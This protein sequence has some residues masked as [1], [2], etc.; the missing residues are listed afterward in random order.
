MLLDTCVDGMSMVDEYA[1]R[2]RAE[3]EVILETNLELICILPCLGIIHIVIKHD[4]Q[5]NLWSV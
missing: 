2:V 1:L 3:F 4:R 5:H